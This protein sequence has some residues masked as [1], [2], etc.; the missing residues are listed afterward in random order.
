VAVFLPTR[1]EVEDLAA[2]LGG[3]WNRLNAAFY[4]GGEPIRVIRPFLDGS[5]PK[6]FL[7]AMTA[8][9]Q[10]ALNIAGLDT[11]VIYDARYANLVER[12]RNVLTRQ[13]LGAN[14]M[15]QMAGRV[16][17]RVRG[18][19]VYLLTDRDLDFESLRPTPPEFQLAGDN[20]RVALTAAA[21]GVDLSELDLPV[22]LDK[23]AYRASVELLTERGI[24]VGGRLTDYGRDVE[25]L[26][27]ERPW[28]ELLVH[29]GGQLIPFVA[30][31][32]NVE[33][34]HRMTRDERDLRGLVVH[35]SDHL[36]AY[37]I[38]AEAVNRYGSVGSVHG[39]PRHLFVEAMEE[40]A[41][42]R[43]VLVKAIE[44]IA[45]GTASVYRTLERALPEK[46]PPADAAVL[47][48]F[49]D[50]LARIMPFDLVLDGH[51]ATGDSARVSRGSMCSA[52]GAVAG[53]VRYFADRFGV[54]RAAIE[55]TN[56]LL[57]LIR[58][59]AVL[60]PPTIEVRNGRGAGLVMV[61]QTRYAGFEL[62]HRHAPPPGRFPAALAEA[63]RSAL[64]AA[65]IEGRTPHPNQ[66]ALVRAV[67]QLGDYWKR[68]GG[69][70][71]EAEP[72]GTRRRV[73]DQIEAVSSWEE[74]LSAPIGLEV[75]ALVPE[76]T[77]RALDALPDAVRVLG[78][79][80]PLVYDLEEGSAVVR[81][82]LKEGQARRLRERDLPAV[83]R[84]LRFTVLRGHGVALRAA[85][86][87]ELREALRSLPR[88]DRQQRRRRL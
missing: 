74:F 58:R 84:P 8:A 46:L 16:H 54:P 78:D 44:D 33:S 88:R 10:S 65:L 56:I 27:V 7:L 79:K 35:G 83:D 36:T 41:E 81:L 61:R 82:R 21:M 15:L 52:W 75:A 29:A 60:I 24:T 28:G 55:G 67:A 9:G 4:H 66:S 40:W 50:L 5:A 18:G 62:E 6:P 11:V 37:N 26:P 69:R 80:V 19:E 22:P 30:V 77:R 39:L 3:R 48:A 71:S 72:H 49:R 47:T 42:R 73:R 43:G 12:G 63:V 14:E 31:A 45:L 85:S 34:L 76:E 25:A 68:S 59:Y 70:L 32:A 86:M 13:Y 38:F 64:A 53:A 51:L 87:D 17:G 2:E 23:R 1:A 57:Y 20:E